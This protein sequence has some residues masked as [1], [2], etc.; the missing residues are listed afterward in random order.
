MPLRYLSSYVYI[1]MHNT[2]GRYLIQ[3]ALTRC[4]HGHSGARDHDPHHYC[5]TQTRL[6]SYSNNGFMTSIGV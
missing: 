6:Q 2:L 4:V 3:R 5:R 1:P